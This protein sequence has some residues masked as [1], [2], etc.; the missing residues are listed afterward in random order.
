MDLGAYWIISLTPFLAPGTKGPAESSASPP[1]TD[2][3]ASGIISLFPPCFTDLETSRIASLP[4]PW[5]VTLETS[6]I[7][8]HPLPQPKKTTGGHRQLVTPSIIYRTLV[9]WWEPQQPLTH[10]KDLGRLTTV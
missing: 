10:T 6:G 2:L 7:I 4:P 3:G 1:P 9:D 8:G 5:P